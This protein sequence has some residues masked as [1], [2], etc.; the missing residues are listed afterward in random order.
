MTAAR[1]RPRLALLD[2]SK[3]EH[4][5]RNFRRELDADLAEFDVTDGELPTDFD[6]DGLVITGSRT[7]VYWDRDW[8]RPLLEYVAA[9]D[10]RDL[11]IL[12]VCWGHQALAEAL[13]GR[14]EDMG[15]YEIGYREIRRVA[16]D[17]LLAGLSDPF[18][19]FTTHSDAVAE[20]PPGADLLAENDYGIHAFRRGDAWGVQF[21]PEYDRDTA[22]GVTKGKDLPDERIRA[23]LDGIDRENYDAACRTKRLFE[24]FTAHVRRVREAP[25]Q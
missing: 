7:S 17:D 18:V 2:A 22:A 12:G 24:N 23:V 20:L 5:R 25:A 9:A 6:F 3:S 4:T 11:P 21:H 8:I 16:D 1:D 19:A 14:V 15:E 13:G 10:E